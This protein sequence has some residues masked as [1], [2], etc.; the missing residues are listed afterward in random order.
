MFCEYSLKFNKKII[1]H[2]ICLKFDLKWPENKLLQKL[3]SARSDL[4][5]SVSA[6]NRKFRTE[7]AD[8]TILKP[9]E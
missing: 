3:L 1:F 5:E 8:V 7:D 6:R 4:S 2:P 9:K